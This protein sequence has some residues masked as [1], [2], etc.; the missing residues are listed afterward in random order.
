M[1]RSYNSA[2]IVLLHF[3][4]SENLVTAHYEKVAKR[5]LIRVTDTPGPHVLKEDDLPRNT[6]GYC[7]K[8]GNKLGRW[9]M[10][11]VRSIKTHTVVLSSSPQ[12][13]GAPIRAEFEGVRKAPQSNMFK[14]WDEIGSVF[15][16][17]YSVLDFEIEHLDVSDLLEN[18]TE[19]E[20]VNHSPSS[21]PVDFP[22]DYHVDQ[23]QARPD[24]QNI[25][26]SDVVDVS[27]MIRTLKCAI[28]LTP[29]FQRLTEQ[30]K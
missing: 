18:K 28:F 15:T 26:L 11:S 22:I 27:A 7:F 16:R 21:A 4:V 14:D 8:R 12:N 19:V 25:Q 17:S 3:P 30:K 13:R 10:R 1:V 5:A 29:K 23:P 24:G 20:D 6:A 2:L 9:H